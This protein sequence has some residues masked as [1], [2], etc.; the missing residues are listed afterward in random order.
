MSRAGD[1]YYGILNRINAK[2]EQKFIQQVIHNF[3]NDSANTE[4]PEIDE[5][6]SFYK[7]GGTSPFPYHLEEKYTNLDAPIVFDNEK[8]LK[9]ILHNGKKLFFPRNFNNTK[10]SR[11]YWGLIIEQ[12]LESPHCYNQNGF[13]IVK[14]DILIDVGCADAMYSLDQIEKINR[15]I[16][17]ETNEFWIEALNAT[18]EPWREKVE[19]V[20]AF[21]SDKT[22]EKHITLDDFF[23]GEVVNK[24]IFLKMDV[25]GSEMSVLNGAK[26]LLES[27][28]QIR[29]AIASYHHQEDFE[30]LSKRLQLI[31][32]TTKSTDGYIL[33]YYDKEIKSPYLRRCIIQ[34]EK[35]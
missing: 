9:Y 19:I 15:L 18:F 23:K 29:I 28:N 22:D 30:E 12:D 7:K 26:A 14:E 4:I 13:D 5:L 6:K 27:D 20:N 24:T 35:Q 21:V 32:Y 2:K 11:L 16:L 1:I 17:F 34:A 3:V 33:F 31:N 8:Q 10:I 25:E